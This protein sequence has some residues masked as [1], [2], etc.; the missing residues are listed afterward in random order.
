MPVAGRSSRSLAATWR[1]LGTE[2]RA[3]GIGAL[4]L[5]VSTLGPFSWIEAAILVV[6]AGVLLL[7]KKRADGA[8]F[9]V[10][11]GDGTVIAAAGIWAGVLVLTRLFDRSLGQELLALGCAAI[12]VVAGLAERAKRPPDDV[13]AEPRPEGQARTEPLPGDEARTEPLAEGGART[14]PVPPDEARTEPLPPGEAKREGPAGPPAPDT[15]S[16]AP[17]RPLGRRRR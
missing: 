2:Q 15:P 1:A 4:L 5:A 8:A 6:C 14:E 7:L 3:A 9:H 10:P 11:F 17:T 16:E 13:A 12:V